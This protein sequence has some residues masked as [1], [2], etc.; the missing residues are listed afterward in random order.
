MVWEDDTDTWQLD[1]FFSFSHDGG[2][3]FSIPPD[4][5][6]NNTGNSVNPQISSDTETQQQ[7]TNEIIT[8]AGNNNHD[9]YQ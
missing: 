6:S 2:Q 4:N 1:I 7:S 9:N 8:T 5:L 3:T